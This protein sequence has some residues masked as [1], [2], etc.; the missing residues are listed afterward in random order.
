MSKEQLR[1]RIALTRA[2]MELVGWKLLVQDWQEEI[3][4]LKQ[5]LIYQPSTSQELVGFNRGKLN[6]LERLVNMDKVLDSVEKSLEEG[7][8]E[9]PESDD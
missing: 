6:V 1:E 2:T 8:D 9:A 7:S 4:M 3:E 5:T